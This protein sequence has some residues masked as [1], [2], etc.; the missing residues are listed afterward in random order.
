ML[1]TAPTVPELLLCARLWAESCTCTITQVLRAQPVSGR[2]KT[3]PQVPLW[4]LALTHGVAL[5]CPG[6]SS[7]CRTA[8]ECVKPEELGWWHCH[9]WGDPEP[10]P[11]LW[12]SDLSPQLTHQQG[13]KESI[14]TPSSTWGSRDSE[15]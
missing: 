2:A 5:P 3:A 9:L 11:V 6:L 14:I 4:S 7:S 12:A 15:R 13:L 1:V 10:D 8:C